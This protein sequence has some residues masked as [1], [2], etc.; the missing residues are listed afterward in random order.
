ME[1][2]RPSR[3]PNTRVSTIVSIRFDTR[4]NQWRYAIEE[5]KIARGGWLLRL[6]ADYQVNGH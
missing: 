6:D 1:G 5:T 3:F 2:W 4:N